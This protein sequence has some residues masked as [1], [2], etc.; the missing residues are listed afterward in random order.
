MAK[1]QCIQPEQE[2]CGRDKYPVQRGFPTIGRAVI[3][4]RLFQSKKRRENKLK[5]KR[6]KDLIELTRLEALGLG[7][8]RQNSLIRRAGCVQKK[9][10]T[11][12]RVG[13]SGK[14]YTL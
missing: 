7:R 3:I 13:A 5:P 8:M 12:D 9:M 6:S 14:A 11:F 1:T 10:A 4:S 2:H